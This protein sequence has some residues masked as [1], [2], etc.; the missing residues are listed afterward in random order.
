MKN[1]QE[2]KTKRLEGDVFKYI[3]IAYQ[4]FSE[5][6]QNIE[7][8]SIRYL[9]KDD[10]IEIAFI[11]H[12]NKQQGLV[13]GGRTDEGRVVHYHISLL[14]NQIIKKNFAR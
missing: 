2:I 4:D 6:N 13:L 1:G 9:K 11:P 10:E 8:Y 5:S 12:F 7:K 3:M 14:T